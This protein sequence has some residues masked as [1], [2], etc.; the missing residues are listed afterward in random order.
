MYIIW[1][2]RGFFVLVVLLGTYIYFADKG[3]GATLTMAYALLLA[4]PIVLLLGL[5]F[6]NAAE[7]KAL[8]IAEE[9]EISTLKK[10]WRNSLHNTFGNPADR[11]S[12]FFIPMVWWSV[13]LLGLGIFNYFESEPTVVINEK[14]TKEVPVEYLDKKRKW[15]YADSVNGIYR[16]GRWGRDYTTVVTV[17]PS[18]ATYSLMFTS[19]DTKNKP[20]IH[21]LK[22]SVSLEGSVFTLDHMNQCY[23]DQC[24]Y[25]DKVS[26][27]VLP[28]TEDDMQKLRR[29]KFLILAFETE[30]GSEKVAIPL[31]GV[32][33]SLNMISKKL[34]RNVLWRD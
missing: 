5:Y 21:L 25:D 8:K 28:L 4:A 22:A 10:L 24:I 32:T 13:I 34:Q 12:F 3:Y 20:L 27:L 11:P 17:E 2:G 1:K 30:T 31:H 9:G 19:R 16:V 33:A 23:G 15:I 14:K 7:K 18:T 29:G 26:R 6:N